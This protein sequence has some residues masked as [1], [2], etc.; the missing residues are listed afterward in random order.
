MFPIL[1]K[2][3][4]KEDHGIL[5]IGNDFFMLCVNLFNESNPAS[6]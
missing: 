3:V 5:R 2:I 1:L 4:V 6:V